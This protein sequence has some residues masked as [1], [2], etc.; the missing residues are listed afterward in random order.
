MPIAADSR[1]VTSTITTSQGRDAET[2]QEMRVAFPR[3]RVIT[4]T[5]YRVLDQDRIDL[6][7]HK[8][9][10][11]GDLWWI[12]ADANPEVIDWMDLPPGMIIRVPNA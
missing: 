8:F 4:F 3:S 6:I 1:Y 7:A 9:Y 12:I 10:S 5:Y 11:R 2:R